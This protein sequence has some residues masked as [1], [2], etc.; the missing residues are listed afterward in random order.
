MR[1]PL[2]RGEHQKCAMA[3]DGERIQKSLRRVRKIAKKAPEDPSPAE[4]HKIRTSAR[5]L[6]S[7]FAAIRLDSGKNQKRL[8][9]VVKKIRKRA[10]RVRDLDVLTGHLTELRLD[11]DKECQIKLLEHLGSERRRQAGKLHSLLSG[12]RAELKTRSQKASAQ[13]DK[14][15]QNNDGE[16]ASSAAARALQLSSE[17]DDPKRLNRQN[18]HPYRLKVKQLRYLLQLA[19]NSDSKFVDDLGDVKDAIGEWHDWE[20]LIASATDVLDHAGGCELMRKLKATS[21]SKYEEALDLAENLRKNY[22]KTPRGKKSGSSLRL[23]DEALR[24]TEAL[25]ESDSRAA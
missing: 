3:I 5:K 17:M 12:N 7:A 16:P 10:G 9:K 1:E 15:L 13:L 22:L 18:L 20:E 19:R 8:L 4:V 14:A 23:A 6:E 2:Y 11:G 21:N 25:S 24:S